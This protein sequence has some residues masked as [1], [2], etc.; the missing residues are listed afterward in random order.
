MPLCMWAFKLTCTQPGCKRPLTKAG[1]YKTIRRVLDIDGWYLMATEYL[2][3]QRCQKKVAGWS[4]DVL[5]RLDPA[6]RNQF[7]AILTYKLTCDLRVM[8][9]LRERSLGNSATQLYRKLCEGHSEAWM[10][11]S[12][13]YLGEC[14]HFLAMGSERHDFPPPPSHAARA[15]TPLAAERLL[16]RRSDATGGGEGQGHLHLRIH[17]QVTKKLA[18]FAADTAAWATNVGNEFGQVLITVLTAA[19]GQGLLPMAAGLMQS[20]RDAGV[21]PPQLIY[22][23][24]DCCS[25]FDWT[26][27]TSCAG[28]LYSCARGSTSLESF[29]LHLNRFIPGDRANAM[30]FQAFLLDRLVSWNEDRAAAAVE[31]PAQPLLSYSGHLQHSLNQLSQR[32]LGQSLVKDYTKPGEYTGALIGVEYLYSQTGRVLQDVSLDPDTP[33]EAAD[34]QDLDLDVKDDGFQE[35]EDDP[36][37]H[38]PTPSSIPSISG[39]EIQL[40]H[41][42]LGH[43]LQLPLKPFL[44]RPPPSWI[45][46]GCPLHRLPPGKILRSSEALTVSQATSMSPGWPVPWWP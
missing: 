3:C 20:Y 15:H 11:R 40:T 17:S 22:V 43:H 28:S 39:Q 35:E 5:N 16:L 33:D 34:I 6:H 32:V 37:V 19:E 9:L 13:Q 45:F 29:H 10:R 30:H 26:C 1:L 2:S 23:D 38:C 31:G 8:R 21:A 18:G 41:P 7:P 46:P 12:M 14:E 42:H 36:T 44:S 27:G 24:R 4:H 25:S